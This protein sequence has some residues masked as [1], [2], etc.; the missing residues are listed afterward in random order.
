MFDSKNK[1]EIHSGKKTV[2]KKTSKSKNR[3]PLAQKNLNLVNIQ[4][5]LTA[6]CPNKDQKEM[7]LNRTSS[8][9]FKKEESSLKKQ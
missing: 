7:K 2:V 8:L 5:D 4:M 6:T 3:A 1:R 9:S